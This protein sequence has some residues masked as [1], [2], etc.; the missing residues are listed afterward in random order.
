[1]ATEDFVVEDGGDGET[2]EAVR[3]RF[4]QFDRETALAFVVET[5]DSVD[6][7]AFVVSTEKEKVF[8]ILDFVS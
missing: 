6:G 3:E 7:G 5:I 2:V 4:P 1:M 8:G